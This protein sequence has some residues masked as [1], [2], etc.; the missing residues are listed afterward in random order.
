[1]KQWICSIGV[2]F[3]HQPLRW[4]GRKVNRGKSD[5][6]PSDVE[7]HSVF[8]S[9]L[10]TRLIPTS[11]TIRRIVPLLVESSDFEVSSNRLSSYCLKLKTFS[12]LLMWNTRYCCINQNDK[13]RPVILCN[14]EEVLCNVPFSFLSSFYRNDVLPLSIPMCTT[15]WCAKI[16]F[17]SN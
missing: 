12:R 2:C 14:I 6:S 17:D 3:S 8:C 10:T 7:P 1:M 13:S 16:S 9:V 4:T 15:V 11:V 5:L